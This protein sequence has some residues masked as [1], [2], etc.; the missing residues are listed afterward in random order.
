MQCQMVSFRLYG[1]E[2]NKWTGYL[3]MPKIAMAVEGTLTST[4]RKPVIKEEVD[5]CVFGVFQSRKF[6]Y[7]W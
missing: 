7:G 4:V 1:W 3:L 2:G 5:A 6:C